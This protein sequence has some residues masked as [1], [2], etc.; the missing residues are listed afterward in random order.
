[1][2]LPLIVAI[3]L[4]LVSSL[5]GTLVLGFAH[6]WVEGRE[7]ATG[8]A[9]G[10]VAIPTAISLGVQSATAV[11]PVAALTAVHLG[12]L[13]GAAVFLGQLRPARAAL[14]ILAYF[15]VAAVMAAGA[16]AV[17]AA[18]LSVLT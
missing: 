13:F 5:L 17:S 12:L 15:V 1:M 16:A 10:I 18:V 6:K 3:P 14:V 9:F 4:F 8:R 2:S 7:L 11:L